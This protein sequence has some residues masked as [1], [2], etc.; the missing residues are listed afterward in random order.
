M[1]A[2]DDAA[3]TPIPPASESSDANTGRLI[4]GRFRLQE[5]LGRGGMGR[6]YRA[7]DDVLHRTVAVK[8]I[9]DDAIEDR[10]IRHASALEARAAAQLNHP[11]IVRILDSGFDDG[12]LYV[13]MSLADGP[14]LTALLR[15]EGRLSVAR[16]REIGV[17][18]ADALDAAHRAGVI[19]CDVKPGNLIVRPDG[20]VQL[21]DFGIARMATSTTGLGGATLQGSAEYVAPEQVEG[22]T[23]D[24]RTDIFALGVVLYEML[25]G[26]TPY[27]GG[28]IT[29]VLARRLVTDPPS[30][31]AVN[32]QVPPEM[33]RVVQKAL[34]RDPADRFQ[35]A[36]ELRDALKAVPT[37]VRA[38]PQPPGSLS[39]TMPVPPLKTQAR[40]QA[41]HAPGLPGDF[42][43]HA[44][45]TGSAAHALGPSL[46]RRA[47]AFLGGIARSR[48][49]SLQ[50]AF[51][52]AVALGLLI[53]V[54]AARW[55]V[56]GAAAES[57]SAG[58]ADTHAVLL[59]TAVPTVDAPPQTTPQTEA[60][61]P[62]P[63][64]PLATPTTQPATPTYPPA[65]PPATAEAAA[66]PPSAPPAQ[67][68]IEPP[69]PELAAPSTEGPP[70]QRKRQDDEELK[71]EWKPDATVNGGRSHPEG[72]PESKP[73]GRAEEKPAPAA[74]PEPKLKAP[75]RPKPESKPSGGPSNGHGGP[76]SKR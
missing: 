73:Q 26:R 14:S 27:G 70:G 71:D 53:G 24:G 49:R 63:T 33:D 39:A 37:V 8:L 38:V 4:A 43:R 3:I 35:T 59:P 66:P 42:R 23:V 61:A 64:L 20:R 10:D 1:P 68:L 40:G 16:V 45:L 54:L 60:T 12:H 67:L 50:I 17:Q 36:A 32:P 25:T 29:T 74:K 46:R 76:K 57:A 13:V 47:A 69:G 48:R 56:V 58:R 28:T 51:G 30:A 15:A 6:V 52:I 34:Q 21:V 31:S 7:H 41:H 22:T 44:E 62:A 5:P 18:V 9:Y 72:K 65:T 19:H 75:S 11:G 2:I 55:N